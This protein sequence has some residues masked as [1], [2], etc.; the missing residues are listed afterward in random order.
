MQSPPCSVPSLNLENTDYTNH[1]A[2]INSP[3]SLSLMKERGLLM[4]DLYFYNFYEYR[5]MHPEI[6]PLSLEIQ[7]SH[8]YHM[9]GIREETLRLM[10]EERRQ[11]IRNE[12]ESQ[13]KKNFSMNNN[14][15][16]Q[17]KNQ[18]TQ[19]KAD[20]SKSKTKLSKEQKEIEKCREKQKKEL[21][22]MIETQL[23]SAFLKQLS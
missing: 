22:A 7:K 8:F 21:L 9:Q 6:I 13:S 1:S 11:I 4:E 16:E 19:Q 12:L 3:R 15:K 23:K 10:I 17:Q 2:Y 18:S 14:T 20:L 5:E